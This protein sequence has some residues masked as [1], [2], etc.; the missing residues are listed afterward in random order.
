MSSVLVI[1]YCLTNHPKAQWL[2]TTT[3][4]CFACVSA[5]QAG[6]SEASSPLLHAMFA[7]ATQWSMETVGQRICFQDDA[8][9]R[10][11]RWFCLPAR[12]SARAVGQGLW[13]PSK[14]S[15]A[16]SCP[17]VQKLR[18]ASRGTG[19]SILFCDLALGVRASLLGVGREVTLA[20]S[21]GTQ[22]LP[23]A[24]VTVTVTSQELMWDERYCR[25]HFLESTIC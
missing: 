8:L 20:C 11:A 6:L 9:A 24:G 13:I 15:W 1:Y 7:G 19:S 14:A 17:G 12:I 16:P 25:G 4:I 5:T 21:E 2:E 18:Q 10:L 22:A 23:L 3:I